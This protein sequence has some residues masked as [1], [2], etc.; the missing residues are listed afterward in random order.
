MCSTPQLV[1]LANEKTLVMSLIILDKGATSL[2]PKCPQRCRRI[3][4]LLSLAPASSSSLTPSLQSAD[5]KLK[6]LMSESTLTRAESWWRWRRPLSSC[7]RIS[8]ACLA[9]PTARP[10]WLYKTSASDY[11][12]RAPNERPLSLSP[13]TRQCVYISRAVLAGEHSIHSAV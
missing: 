6:N 3:L 2:G 9:R 1:C 4:S 5:A 8:S 10:T 13:S 11:T 12:R 7:A